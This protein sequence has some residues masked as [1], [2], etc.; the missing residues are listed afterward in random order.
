MYQHFAML[1][2]VKPK[3]AYQQNMDKDNQGNGANNFHFFCS[4]VLEHSFK[5]EN[6]ILLDRL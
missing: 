6:E 5:L 1:V 4:K 3:S 2:R